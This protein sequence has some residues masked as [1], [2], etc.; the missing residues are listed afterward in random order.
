M[1]LIPTKLKYIPY[2]EDVLDVCV[3]NNNFLC[4]SF[5]KGFTFPIYWANREC[6]EDFSQIKNLFHSETHPIKKDVKGIK[7]TVDISSPE[8]QE[9]L[10]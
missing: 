8:A 10:F 2:N 7:L 1:N 3:D 4:Q 5:E 9:I 6:I